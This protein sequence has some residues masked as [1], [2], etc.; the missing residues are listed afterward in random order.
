VQ[1]RSFG[2]DVIKAFA[3]R[4][5]AWWFAASSPRTLG[6]VRILGGL[7]GCW[8]WWRMGGHFVRISSQ[9]EF[10]YQPVGVARLFEHPIPVE[11]YAGLLVA[12][13]VITVLFTLGLAFR[14]VGPLFALLALF[15]ATYGGN[16]WSFI[17]HT[18]NV[19]CLHFLVLGFTPSAGAL[20][21]DSFLAPRLPRWLSW[22]CATPRPGVS[23]PESGWPVR[24]MQLCVVLPYLVAGIAKV[25][26]SGIGWAH[27]DNLRD[28]IVV[29]GLYYELITGRAP[30]ITFQVYG[31]E[32]AFAVL[33]AG[34]LVLELGAPL[35]LIRPVG[36]LFVPAVMSLHWGIVWLMGID[37]PYQLYGAAYACFVP[38]QLLFD[39]VTRGYQR[40]R[41]R[42]DELAPAVDQEPSASS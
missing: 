4:L 9:P 2:E 28:Q 17:F 42:R 33:A 27:G 6:M 11:I 3:K 26:L 24:L 34:S 18:E 16:S 5:S 38:W 35:A 30:D 21:A 13:Q 37:F 1:G 10:L 39:G 32:T 25:R 12:L 15:V 20:S 19:T 40:L 8:F 31:W 29:N 7:Y 23:D 41:A 14:I 36:Y 22:C